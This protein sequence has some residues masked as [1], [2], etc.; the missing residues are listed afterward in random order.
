MLAKMG[1][2]LGLKAH[3]PRTEALH[4]LRELITARRAL[5]KDKVAAKTR[6][7]TTRQ[8]LLKNQ[9]NARLKQIKIQIQ[10]VDAAITEKVAQDEALSNK[11]DILTLKCRNW[12]RSKE[13]RLQV[14]PA[15]HRCRGSRVN[16]KA[17]NASRADEHFYGGPSTCPLWSQRGTIPVSRQN[18]ISSFAQEN[19][20]KSPLQRS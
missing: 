9:I 19:L 12:G 8:T 4:I 11:L 15:S 20:G 17:R 5:M 2:I 1:A 7:Q 16:G 14:S 18:T 6:L 3:E 13:S 10:Q